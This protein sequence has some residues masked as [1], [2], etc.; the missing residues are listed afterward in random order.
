MVGRIQNSPG[1]SEWAQCNH[2]GPYK[3]EEGGQRQR[4]RCEDESKCQSNAAVNQ[5]M[6][7]ASRSWKEQGEDPPVKSP[8]GMQP[9]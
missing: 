8:E 3:R 4:R 1:L 5:G 6:W 9:C 2:R 7:T